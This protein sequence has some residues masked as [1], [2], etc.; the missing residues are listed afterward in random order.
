MTLGTVIV[1]LIV[2][3]IVLSKI[4]RML[5]ARQARKDEPYS[6]RN[7]CVYCSEIPLIQPDIKVVPERPSKG[8]KPPS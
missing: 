7:S 1:A 2:L 5:K 3:A 8:T 6:Q 4:W